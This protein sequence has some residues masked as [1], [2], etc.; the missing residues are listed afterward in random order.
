MTSIKNISLGK[1]IAQCREFGIHVNVL[2]MNTDEHKQLAEQTNG[3]W[4]AIPEDTIPTSNKRSVSSRRSRYQAQQLR[5]TQWS[6]ATEIGKALLENL[7]TNVLDV[8][9]LIDGSKSMENKLPKF[10]KQLERM[11]RDWDNALID[12]QIGVVRFRT[13]V[14]TLIM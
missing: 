11:I 7:E 4:H 1:V 12:Y 2:G 13:G 6:G 8:I 10:L 5:R 9:L 3:V 14:G